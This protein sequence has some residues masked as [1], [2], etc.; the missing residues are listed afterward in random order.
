MKQIFDKRYKLYP[1][2]VCSLSEYSSHIQNK[3]DIYC[4]EDNDM[5]LYILYMLHSNISN[6]FEYAEKVVNF[7]S[8]KFEEI[9]TFKEIMY[10]IGKDMKKIFKTAVN[11]IDKYSSFKLENVLISMFNEYLLQKNKSKGPKVI[12][13]SLIHI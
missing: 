12:H 7:D 8:M 2:N 1:N 5:S 10:L 9:N 4:S 6:L 3:I 13:L 11:T